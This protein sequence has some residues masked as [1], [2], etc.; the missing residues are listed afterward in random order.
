MNEEIIGYNKVGKDQ[1]QPITEPKK[2]YIYTAAIIS[3]CKCHNIISGMGG[4]RPHAVCVKC[5]DELGIVKN[6]TV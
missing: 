6:E 2:G 3:C 1:Y 4:P 5:A